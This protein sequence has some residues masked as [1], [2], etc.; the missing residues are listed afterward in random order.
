MSI[1]MVR[2]DKMCR[3]IPH[4]G[5][6]R[7]DKAVY[8]RASV[9][10]G[11]RSLSSFIIDRDV[12]FPVNIL[13]RE[14]LKTITFRYLFFIVI[15]LQTFPLCTSCWFGRTLNCLS[16][17]T[18]SW[19]LPPLGG[20]LSPLLASGRISA[21]I[22]SYLW[23]SDAKSLI[24]NK[25]RGKVMMTRSVDMEELTGYHLVLMSGFK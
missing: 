11:W 2:M 3:S 10:L 13:A 8:V 17:G 5:C 19:L 6:W 21:K 16:L 23:A 22:G 14:I 9:T 4:Y 24:D 7:L 12:V 18:V 20:P 25:K 15:L 1:L